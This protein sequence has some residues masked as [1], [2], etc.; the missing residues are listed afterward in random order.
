MSVVVY[1]RL[2]VHA[3]F[4]HAGA[5]H[6]AEDPRVKDA[7]E[8]SSLGWRP[9]GA[10]QELLRGVASSIHLLVGIATLDNGRTLQGDT[11]K[12]TLGLGVAK[13]SRYA[14]KRS[15]TGGLGVATDGTSSQRH[16]ATKGQGTGLGKCLDGAGI[17][18]DEDEVGKFE[19]NLATEAGASSGD[20]TRGAPGAIGE[21]CD[22]E[23]TAEAT[24][25]EEAGLEDGDDGEALGVGENVGRDDLFGAEGLARADEG[26]EDL[27]AL[28]TFRC[29]RG[30]VIMSAGA[31]ARLGSDWE[32]GRG[33]EVRGWGLRGTTYTP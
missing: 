25:S 5:S 7:H 19:T 24:R 21:A 17:V 31:S 18:E 27:A 15:S 6:A 26:G 22:N 23:A 30:E 20:S 29:G 13:D 8:R 12:Q 16:I 10:R 14:P 28:F 4:S 2:V 11:S 1:G 33:R 3:V 32:R 9:N